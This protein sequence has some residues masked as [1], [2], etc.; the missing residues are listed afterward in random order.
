MV[1]AVRS[2]A[3]RTVLRWQIIATG[4]LAAIAGVI[5]EIHGAAS[6]ALGGMVNVA[7]G[8]AF[9]WIATR[10]QLASS[11]EALRTVFR[12]E[13]VKILLVIIQSWL[14]WSLYRQIVVPAFLAAFVVTVVVS[15]MA[16]AVKDA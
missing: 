8:W 3:L 6:A 11:G 1:F 16:I 14:V 5:W 10:R 12:A 9:G 2:R 15:T 13:G 7:A 4:I